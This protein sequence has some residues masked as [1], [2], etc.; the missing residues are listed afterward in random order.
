MAESLLL[1][2]GPD[3]FDFLKKT[4]LNVDGVDD[5]GEWRIL[6]VSRLGAEICRS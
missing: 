5:L 3:H 2:H 6:K 1:E 4:R